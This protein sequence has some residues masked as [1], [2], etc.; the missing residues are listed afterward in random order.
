MI[1]I[2]K[3][4]EKYKYRLYFIKYRLYVIKYRLYLYK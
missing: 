2:G 3:R 4:K 1:K